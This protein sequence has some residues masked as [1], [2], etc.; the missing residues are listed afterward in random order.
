MS[1][2]S[3][4]LYALWWCFKNWLYIRNC[5]SRPIEPGW[6][7]IFS[8]FYIYPMLK[9]IKRIGEAHGFNDKLAVGALAT[10]FILITVAA[11]VTGLGRMLT[12]L[13]ILPLLPVQDY[14]NKLNKQ[15]D[16]EVV[17]NDRLTLGNWVWIIL[18]GSTGLAVLYSIF[19][20]APATPWH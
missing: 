14:I 4:G 13:T 15:V 18:G 16:P 12:I 5:I 1:I 9:E 3:S 10:V 17:I 8:V 6:R 7:A 11:Q 20:K 19:I 2:F